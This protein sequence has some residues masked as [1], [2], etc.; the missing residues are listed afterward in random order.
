MRMVTSC[1]R[2]SSGRYFETGSL[3]F[4]LPS[5]ARNRTAAAVNCSPIDPME[6]CIGGVASIA[7]E[8]LAWPYAWR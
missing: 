2:V 1:A 4:S 5:W 3:R 7:G 8:S 6:Y